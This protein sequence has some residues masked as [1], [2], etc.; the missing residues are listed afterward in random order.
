LFVGLNPSTATAD[1]DDPT[2]RREVNFAR[3]DGFDCYLKG[4]LYA[5]RSPTPVALEDVDDPVGPYNRQALERMVG[6]AE[7]VVAAWGTSR[8]SRQA[9]DIA[10][11]IGSLDKTRC[12]GFTKDG[13]PKHPLYVS[14]TTPLQRMRK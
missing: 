1:D 11:W 8:L 10:H 7:V 9:R 13:S 12:L 5:Y 4:N 2:V 14:K 6:R 3:R